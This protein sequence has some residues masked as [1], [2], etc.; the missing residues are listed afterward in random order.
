M[1]PV[2]YTSQ[3]KR[4]WNPKFV[5]GWC[6]FDVFRLVYIFSWLVGV[7]IFRFQAVPF[8]GSNLATK[9]KNSGCQGSH[10]DAT[11]RAP[12]NPLGCVKVGNSFCD[13]NHHMWFCKKKQQE[14]NHKKISEKFRIHVR[15]HND[16][17]LKNQQILPSHFP[18]SLIWYYRI[19]QGAASVEQLA[20]FVHETSKGVMVSPTSCWMRP[21]WWYNSYLPRKNRT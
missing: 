14:P 17:R 2:P 11:S 1:I 19:I 9:P 6:F 4:I 15:Y 7:Y 21:C 3:K 10:L 5:V 8:S 18:R 20:T 16:F 13:T 12:S